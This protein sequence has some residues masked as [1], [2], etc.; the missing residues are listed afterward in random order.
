MIRLMLPLIAEVVN[1]KLLNLRK[2]ILNEL[3]PI[4]EKVKEDSLE[5][6]Q[7]FSIQFKS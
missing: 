7:S 4:L 6:E 3:N 2:D 1:R 5:K